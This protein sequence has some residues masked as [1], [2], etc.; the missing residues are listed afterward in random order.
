M[1]SRT[2]LRILVLMPM[3]VSGCGGSDVSPTPLATPVT[4]EVGRV[5]QPP[6]SVPCVSPETSF[7]GCAYTRRGVT[8]TGQVYEATE[9]GPVGI[10]GADVYCEA[11][12]LTTH[13]WAKSD[14]NGFYSFS[15]DLASGG[16]VWLAPG[17]LTAISIQHTGYQDPP[18]LPPLRGPMF[19]I[20][21]GSG[22]REVLIEGDTR[23]DIQLVRR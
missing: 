11:C 12:G 23:F 6:P 2:L 9:T 14:K 18:G 1:T 7:Y 17:F 3:A 13:T 22:W 15:G 5:F 10:A 4:P 8:L 21:D 20:P 16:G 19:H